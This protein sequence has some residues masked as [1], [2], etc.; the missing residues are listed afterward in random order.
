VRFR[1]QMFCLVTF[2]LFLKP[3]LCLPVGQGV[4]DGSNSSREAEGARFL[5]GA[6]DMHF[7]M[8]APT[9]ITPGATMAKVRVAR[10]LGLRGLVL[11]SHNEPTAT[12][13]YQIGL[14]MPGFDVFGGVVLNRPNGGINVAAVEHLA[15]IRG[16]PGRVVWM[17][18]LD[19]ESSAKG[20]PGQPFVAVSRNGEL[21]PEVVAVISVIAKNGFVLASGHIAAG[22]ALMVFREARLQGVQHMIATHP[23]YG[24]GKMTMDQMLEAAKLG[25]FIE[26][27]F[28]NGISHESV[29][30]A[31]DVASLAEVIRRVGPEHCFLS[32]FWTKGDYTGSYLPTEYGNLDTVGAFVEAMHAHGFTDRDLDLLAKQNP[33]RLLGLSSP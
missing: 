31:E 12:L 32:E 25:A 19:S 23:M 17:P 6:I 8:D 20:H 33:A 22:D 7:H 2:V 5:K 14:D 18:T 16:K 4:T 29:G 11:K 24:F 13:A 26:V 15:Q 28:R 27:D 21:L 9:E 10:S 3:S 1:Y 30:P